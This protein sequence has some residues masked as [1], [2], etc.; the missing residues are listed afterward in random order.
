M[1]GFDRSEWVD[2]MRT[3]Q[4]DIAQLVASHEPTPECRSLLR[5]AIA[6][7]FRLRTEALEAGEP[8][9]VVRGLE[10]SIAHALRVL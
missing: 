9:G 10:C 8:I 2:G 5:I 4:S 3:V 6:E 7:G 1:I